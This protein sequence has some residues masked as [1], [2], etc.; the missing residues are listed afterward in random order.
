[1]SRKRATIAGPLL[2]H[3][4]GPV[5]PTRSATHESLVGAVADEGGPDRDWGIGPESAVPQD[6]GALAIGAPS[7][8]TSWSVGESEVGNTLQTYL[9]EIR[10]A[11]LLT[12]QQE[13][14]TATLARQGDFQARQAMIEHNLRLVVSIA[15]HY[16][17]R[18]LP[19]SDLIEEG[20]LGL[21]HAI[22]KFEPERG[23]RFSTVEV[24]FA[25]R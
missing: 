24:S 7:A 15:K 6:A 14:D 19:M 4:A 3:D 5:A 8:E 12:P 13:F 11:P 17:G 25:C 21:M 1:M 20:N 9:R 18:G 22:E 23:F 2:N 10:R 16:V